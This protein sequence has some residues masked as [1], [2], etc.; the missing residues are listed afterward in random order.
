MLAGNKYRIYEL[1]W[2]SALNLPFPIS[3]FPDARSHN[4]DWTE[5]MLGLGTVT[6][7]AILN[8]YNVCFF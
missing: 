3:H 5:K 1:K 2:N 6:L 8:V 7:T 4:P